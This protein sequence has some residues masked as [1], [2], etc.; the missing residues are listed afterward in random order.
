MTGRS[1]RSAEGG[2]F[3]L[4]PAELR[5]R[6]DPAEFPFETTDQIE[7]CPIRIIGQDRALEALRVGLSIWSDGYNIFVAGEVG[8]GRSTSVRR[9]L[10]SLDRQDEA[11]DDLVYVHNSRSPDQ[12]KLLTFPAGRGRAFAKAVEDLVEGLRRTLPELFES[13]LY[14][15]QRQSRVEGAQNAQKDRLKEFERRV[16]QEGFSLVQIQMGPLVRPDLAPVVAGNPVPVDQL[17]TLVEEG[18]FE[19]EQFERLRK[20]FAELRE[21]LQG[22]TKEFRKLDRSLRQDLL[23]LDEELARPLVEEAAGDVLE[24]FRSPAVEAYLKD[25][26]EDVLDHLDTF[27]ETEEPRPPGAERDR[28]RAEFRERMRPYAVNLLV[29]HAETQGRPILWEST[30]SYR[31]LFGTIDTAR[32]TAGEW[33]SDHTRI[34]AGSL[35]R[36]SG[37]FLVL[38]AMD[39]LVEPGVWPA[40]KR[41]LRTRIL[42]VRAH[43]PLNLFTSV[44]LK[45]E[46]IPLDVK[47]ILIGTPQI[48][49][50]LYALDEDFQ[51]IFKVKAD[52]AL[53]TPRTPMELT[54]YTCFIHK[55]CQD[56]GL[57]PFHRSAVAAVMEHGVRIAG[58]K[59]KM[60]TRFNEVADLIREAGYW[61]RQEESARVEERHVDRAIAERVRR[62]DL[63][64][65]TLR[66]RIADGTLLLDIEGRKVGQV[67]GL[68]IL[69]L[70]DYAFGTPARI[71]AVVAMGRAGI[72]HI[73]REAELS[74]A[75]HTK[76]VLTLAGFMR[77]R[78]AQDKPL[79]LTATLTFEQNY[80]AVE[81][82]SASAA[83]LCALLS[84]L[85]DVPFRQGIAVTGSVNQKG[86][87]QPIGGVN[88]KIEGYYD[89]CHIRG[90]DGEQGVLIPARNVPHLM[91][92]KDV[93]EA[94]E[95]GRFHV[96]A[97]RT[98]EEGIEILSGVPAGARGADGLYPQ[99][100]VFER[101]DARLR[102][103]A[104]AV[105]EF[106]PADGASP[107]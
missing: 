22:I 60:T 34:R 81:G 88:E 16:E 72:L 62:L 31:N 50:L 80:A 43:D 29:D 48:Y 14:R 44:S 40:L 33:V 95:K 21:T 67:N 56:D 2:P 96:W 77:S 75:L 32:D 27:R 70:G 91:L 11:P 45:P 92:R 94:V 12:P 28:A 79:T 84:S 39:L 52:F 97:V 69:D 104:R 101:V 71:T 13:G 30:P 10:A 17:E 15:K 64:E 86:E 85:S 9:Q 103:L 55:K 99:G 93:V 6:C 98:I 8:T 5:W 58:S 54:N 106:G 26:V 68:M 36:A 41:T 3:R 107:V 76:G 19:R 18:R 74:G 78:F 82:D 63:V 66:E 57:P 49:R 59:E 35:A 65:E 47:V 42:E 1:R 7:E 89:L 105:R 46:P 102:E 4:G 61:A 83:E 23:A 51:K 20:K 73:E 100:S 37:G 38:D 87:V 90:L 25:V 24:A 53:R